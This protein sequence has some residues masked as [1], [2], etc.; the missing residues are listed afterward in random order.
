QMGYHALMVDFRGQGG[1]SGT[2]TTLGLREAEDVAAAVA[3]ADTIGLPRPYVT[4]GVSTG[5]VAIMRAIRDG[6][7]VDAALLEMPFAHLMNAVKTRMKAQDFPTWGV[8]ELLVFWGGVQHGY[9]AFA[10]N[11]VR[12]ARAL[13]LPTLILQGEKDRWTRLEEVQDIYHNLPG[14]KEMVVFPGAGH[15]LLVTVDQPLWTEAIADF[16][17]SH[18]G[19]S[20]VSPNPHQPRG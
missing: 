8:A 6:L 4:Y 9:N 17:T 16:L 3:H 10:H 12:Y 18:L 15:N 19:P 14:A 5:S 13:T 11:P 7:T 2:S 20:S 1:S